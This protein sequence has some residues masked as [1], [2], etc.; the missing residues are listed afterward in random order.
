MKYCKNCG[1]E[2]GPEDKDC[3]NCGKPVED[4]EK[5][6]EENGGADKGA[7]SAGKN[8]R[9]GKN[10]YEDDLAA[11][12]DGMK[13]AAEKAF[14][15]AQHIASQVG[16][17]I[18]EIKEKEE[19]ALEAELAASKRAKKSSG[20]NV[21]TAKFMSATELWSWLKKDAKRQ[22]FYTDERNEVTEEEFVGK[23]EEKMQENGVPAKIEKRKI[24]W[25]RSAV[26][27]ECYFVLPQTEV[28]NP[29]SYILQFNHVGNFSFV[30]EKTFITP[31]ELPEVPGKPKTDA[32]K[33]ASSIIMLV[34]G[35]LFICFGLSGLRDLN[36]L[37]GFVMTLLIL[38]AA[39]AV[40][41]GYGYIKYS[42]IMKYNK[43]CAEQERAWN[44]AWSN[45]RNS[46][47]LYSFQEDINGQLSRIFDA[48]FGCIKQVSD[49]IFKE[50]AAMEDDSSQRMSEL[51]EMIE[52]H[53]EEYR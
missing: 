16:S 8:P 35:I 49:D 12:K 6:P 18:N 23:V 52:R 51:E 14:V 22:L 50:Q 19:A 1:A 40:V 13:N 4:S 21:D 17:K 48:V 46:I 32:N 27:R 20:H 26:Q 2:L 9:E 31:P 36:H 15:G 28:V 7:D 33:Y 3:A 38:G 43:K 42:V 44:L 11:M 10:S 30:E 53:K 39:L 37:A 25:D 34:A 24:Q 29:V 5:A 45:W 47:F 41:G